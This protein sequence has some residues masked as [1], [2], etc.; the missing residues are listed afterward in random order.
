M[1]MTENQKKLLAFINEYRLKNNNSPSLREMVKGIG[2]SDNKSILGIIKTLIVQGYLTNTDGKARS[3]LLTDK[4]IKILGLY[5][6]PVTLKE[7]T[8]GVNQLRQPNDMVRNSVTVLAPSNENFRYSNES[9]KTNG[10]TLDSSEIKT[11][12]ETAVNLAFSTAFK[13]K[14]SIQN[15]ILSTFKSPTF[16]T[17]F[18]WTLVSM[19]LFSISVLNLGKSIFAL[20]SSCVLL[21]S[22]FIIYNFSKK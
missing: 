21:F 5:F 13:Q 10:T 11:V 22:I 17:K 15:S 6:I 14:E 19:F 1:I 4:A 8:E 2:V 3:I 18:E 16:T 12:V 9:V 20:F 7:K